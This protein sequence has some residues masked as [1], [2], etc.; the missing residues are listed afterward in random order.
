MQIRCSLQWL[1][2]AATLIT[3][4]IRSEARIIERAFG[5]GAPILAGEVAC[6]DEHFELTA[7]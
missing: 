6:V 3:R 4:D 2:E 7:A 1:C 5:L